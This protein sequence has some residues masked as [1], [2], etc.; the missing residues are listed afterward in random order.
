MM[1]FTSFTRKVGGCLYSIKPAYFTNKKNH[2]NGVA[3][4]YLRFDY[5]PN[6][7]PARFIAPLIPPIESN[8]EPPLLA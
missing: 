6:N 7:F 3:F 5:L 8:N 1:G 4:S 2:P